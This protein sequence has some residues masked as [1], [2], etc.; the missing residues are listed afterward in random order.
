MSIHAVLRRDAASTPVILPLV[1]AL[2]GVLAGRATASAEAPA[3]WVY[4]DNGAI[5]LGVK[6]SSGAAIGYFAPSQSDTNLINH[7]DHGR[8]VQ[9]S[10]YGAADGSEW[11][12]KPWRW[13]PVQG[14][15]YRGS[16]SRVLELRVERPAKLYAKTSP[17]HWATGADLAEVT[18][19]QWVT[20]HGRV[21]HVRYRMSYA[22]DAAHPEWDQEIPA[23][24]VDPALDT[25]V[26][27]AGDAPWTGGVLERSRPG[28]PNEYHAVDENWA[29]YV[30]KDDVGIGAYVPI[31][32]R[33]T[34]YR[35]GD[36]RGPDA[37]S[38]F[39]PLTRFAVRPGF[40]F[41]YDLYLTTGT[42]DEI[43]QTFGRLRAARDA[44]LD[45]PHVWLARFQ[46]I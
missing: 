7:H 21:A 17:K 6:T 41:G 22:G 42:V 18:M 33:I 39:A 14:G 25:L 15:D 27:Y 44:T 35:F 26:R 43:R 34:G 8:L 5:R 16:A 12:G 9:Q 46:L 45:L 1:V 13:N 30:G 31:A 20:L 23:V 2:I 3:E 36:G 10:Y 38:Y 40:V 24:F 32:R 29:A 37:C 28:W 11:A 19:E 4:L